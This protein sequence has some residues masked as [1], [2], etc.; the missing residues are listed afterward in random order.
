MKTFI[1]RKNILVALMLAAVSLQLTACTDEEVATAVGVGAIVGGAVL[2]GSQTNCQG[3]YRTVC[4][5]FR[6]YYGHW[7]S[8]CRREWD[9]CAYLVPKREA[10]AEGEIKSIEPSEKI[11][12]EVT[13]GETFGMSFDTSQKLLDAVNKSRSGDRFALGSLGLSDS[14]MRKIAQ[15]QLPSDVGID[16]L[17]K[18]LDTDGATVR[19]M[20]VRL[21]EVQKSKAEIAAA[22]NG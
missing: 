22:V 13:W 3:A 21:I 4:H 9:S 16:L 2:I 18:N 11:V 1:S 10:L 19:K 15:L 12:N 5:D 7:H 8:E 6:D 17:A 14:D 20:F